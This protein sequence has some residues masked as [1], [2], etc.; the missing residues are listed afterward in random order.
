MI[1]LIF[2]AILTVREPGGTLEWDFTLLCLRGVKRERDG[3]IL[4]GVLQWNESQCLN[5]EDWTYRPVYCSLIKFILLA[6]PGHNT[7]ALF[8]ASYIKL[9]LY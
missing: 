5:L 4:C 7:I 1:V 6:Y 2:A 8:Y 3:F 9:R